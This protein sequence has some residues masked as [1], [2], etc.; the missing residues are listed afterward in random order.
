MRESERV[1]RPSAPMKQPKKRDWRLAAHTLVAVAYLEYLHTTCS[2]FRSCGAASTADYLVTQLPF[3]ST[4]L[5]FLS[6]SP[7]FCRPVR[8]E[9]DNAAGVAGAGG[10]SA[11]SSPAA[12]RTFPCPTASHALLRLGGKQ[13]QQARLSP[14]SLSPSLSLSRTHCL[15]HASKKREEVS[16]DGE[17]Q[18]SKGERGERDTRRGCVWEVGE[19]KRGGEQGAVTSMSFR[20]L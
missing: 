6:F 2:R 15:P 11:S 3:L 19:Q 1:E 20:C 9:E 16:S 8:V 4:P 12:G 14:I 13:Q 18:E 5:F 17:G 7:A 10:C